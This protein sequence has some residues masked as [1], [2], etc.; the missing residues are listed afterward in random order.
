MIETWKM[1]EVRLAQESLRCQQ[2][3]A[4]ERAGLLTWGEQSELAS[5]RRSLV[6]WGMR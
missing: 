4:M 3:E 2:L 1:R 5:L 6:L